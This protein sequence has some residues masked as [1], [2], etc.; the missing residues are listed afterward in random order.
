M[1]FLFAYKILIEKLLGKVSLE[2]AWAGTI[3]T[4]PKEMVFEDVS[5]L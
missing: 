4:D 1:E 5:S 2:R 3:M